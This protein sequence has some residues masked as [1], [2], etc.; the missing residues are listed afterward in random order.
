MAETISL[1]YAHKFSINTATT[2]TESFAEIN[3]GFNNVAQAINEVLFQ[4][5]FLGDA[6]WGSTEVT[7]GQLIVT[8]SGVRYHGNTA[9]D[10]IFSNAVMNNFGDA[11]KTTFKI[12]DPKGNTIS[13]NI[14]L[15]KITE[16]GGEANQPSSISVEIH[17]NGKPT[18]TEASA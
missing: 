2:G 3:K 15:A 14:T 7:G 11:R 5:S 18:Y 6:G 13:G 9:Q 16:S 1:N 17:F 10:Y 8:L 4:A 12:E